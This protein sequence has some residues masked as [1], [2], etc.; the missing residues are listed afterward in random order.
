[1]R[2]VAALEVA[3]HDSI[4]LDF[5]PELGIP[6]GR[7]WAAEIATRLRACQALVLLASEQAL[8]SRW[9]F[10]ETMAAQDGGKLIYP[11][12]LED[13]TVDWPIQDLQWIDLTGGFDAGMAKL[14]RSLG[15][16]VS[17]AKNR[18]AGKLRC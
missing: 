13:C 7:D 14:T 11:L 4:F 5:H 1:M 12:R 16:A 10:H 15:S 9:C 8:A 17:P 2:V 6:A 18:V 3:G